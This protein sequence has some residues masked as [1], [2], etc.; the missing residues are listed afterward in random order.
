MYILHGNKKWYFDELN[1]AY[2]FTISKGALIDQLPV[3]FGWYS[4]MGGLYIGRSD[5]AKLA[6]PIF[7]AQL[8]LLHC[9]VSSTRCLKK[10]KFGTSLQRH[11]NY[12]NNSKNLGL[13]DFSSWDKIFAWQGELPRDLP[14]DPPPYYAPASGPQRKY[15]PASVFK[16]NAARIPFSQRWPERYAQSIFTINQT[17]ILTFTKHCACLKISRCLHLLNNCDWCMRANI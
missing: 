17:L 10:N 13:C 3:V 14:L 16:Q 4:L 2:F 6:K 1:K 12:S 15:V 8:K 11:C 9:S 5:D 7:Y